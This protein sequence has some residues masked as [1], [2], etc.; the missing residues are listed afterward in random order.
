MGKGDKKSK[1]GKRI[2]KTWGVHRPRTDKNSIAPVSTKKKT[3]K[4]AT[5][6]AAPKKE[7]AKVE[8]VVAA[9][10]A[11]KAAAPK[12]ETA[13]KA[14]PK[15][16][17]AKKDAKGDDLTKVEGIGPKV[18]EVFNAAGIMTFA[19]LAG[20]KVDKLVEILLAAN[21]RYK[22][23]DPTSWP[24]QAKMAADENW[25]ELKKWQDEHDGGKM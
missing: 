4:K 8:E 2:I 1:K 19:D 13:K 5:K 21:S 20:Q 18:K 3:V 10:E 23:F 15:K 16:A 12:K 22:M 6:K 24:I 14:A 17:A 25:D 11:P 9:A 7:T